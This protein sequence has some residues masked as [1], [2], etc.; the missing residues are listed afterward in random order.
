MMM[1]LIQEI[2][3]ISDYDQ[4]SPSSS[5]QPLPPTHHHSSSITNLFNLFARTL[6]SLQESFQQALNNCVRVVWNHGHTWPESKEEHF[7]LRPDPVGKGNIS[8]ID[9]G[10]TEQPITVQGTRLRIGE[11]LHSLLELHL[12]PRCTCAWNT[13]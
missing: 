6:D 2:P 10:V 1:I 5:S 9:F 7:S 12:I 8:K 11:N 13:Q 4:Q 3:L